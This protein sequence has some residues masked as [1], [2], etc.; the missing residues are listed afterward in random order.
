MHY[1]RSKP[2]LVV[3]VACLLLLLSTAAA[4]AAPPDSGAPV[5]VS[6][7]TARTGDLPVR[8]QALGTVTPLTTVTVK[9][10]VSGQLVEIG[11]TEGQIVQPGDFLAQIDPRP[12]QLAAEQAQGVVK[13]DQ[14]A[15]TIARLEL[16]RLQK[17]GGTPALQ[18]NIQRATAAQYEGALQADE[19]ALAAAKATLESAR[20]VSPITGRAGLRQADLSSFVTPADTGGIVVITQLQPI[21]VILPVPEDSATEIA[22]RLAAGVPLPVIASDRSG[23]TPLATGRLLAIDNQIDTS[24]GTVK[25]RAIF[26]NKDGALFPNQFVNVNLVVDTLH[27]QVLIPGTAVLRGAIGTFVYLLDTRQ[28]IVKAK[29]VEVGVTDGETDAIVSGVSAGDVVVAEG[30]DRLRDGARVLVAG[31]GAPH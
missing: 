31:G 25:L 6:V 1:A 19:A 2:V 27:D 28:N 8:I 9:P 22:K 14:A 26:D 24:T 17:D 29:P 11:F 4:F 10:R 3:A 16:A 7:A 15:L 12:Y 30:G 20:M 5:A 21:S 23:S 18:L 13:R